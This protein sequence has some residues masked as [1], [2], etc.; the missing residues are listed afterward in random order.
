MKA[1]RTFLFIIFIISGI[2]LGT[3][4]GSLASNSSAMSWL[5]YGLNF[6]INSASPMVIDLHIITLT[7]GLG[8]SINLA[9]IIFVL[10]SLFIYSVT[11][12][13]F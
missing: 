13:K 11:Y 10:L 9:Q 6:G 8:V 5:S 2:V 7:F 4:I 3:L 12:K 1:K